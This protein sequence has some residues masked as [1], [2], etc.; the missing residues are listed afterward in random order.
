M[1]E[2]FITGVIPC[3][4]IRKP[5]DRIPQSKPHLFNVMA[6]KEIPVSDALFSNPWSIMDVWWQAD[7]KHF[8]FIYNQRGHQ[9]LRIL[10][11]DAATGV[12]RTIV[13]EESKTFIDYQRKHFCQYLQET[14]EILWMSERDGWNHLYRYNGNTGELLNQITRGSWVVRGVDRVEVRQI[15]FHASGMYPHQDPYHVHYGRVNFDGSGLVWLTESDG[16]HNIVYSPDRRFFIDTYSRVDLPPQIE[17][18]GT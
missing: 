10:A 1:Q 12:A 14:N 7:S 4:I 3:D 5:G 9:I 8:M 18:R 11:V 17:L 6:R 15:Y 16:T 13:N 2:T